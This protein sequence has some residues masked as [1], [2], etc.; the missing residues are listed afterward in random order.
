MLALLGPRRIELSLIRSAAALK[1]SPPIAVAVCDGP[2]AVLYVL[3]SDQV[4][5]SVYVQAVQG[6]VFSHGLKASVAFSMIDTLCVQCAGL[7]GDVA[8]CL[9]ILLMCV[10]I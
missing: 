3:D 2:S 10:H 4:A 9:D 5:V 1:G 6:G 8:A 7:L